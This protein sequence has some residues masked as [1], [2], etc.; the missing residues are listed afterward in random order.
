MSSLHI[1]IL[2]TLLTIIIADNRT[3]Y[4]TKS[5][6][7]LWCQE[8]ILS[9]SLFVYPNRIPIGI[10][11]TSNIKSVSYHLI[12]D[13]NNGLFQLKSRRLADFYFL[14][15]N[16]TRPFDINREYQDV[17]TLRIQANIITTHENLTEQTEVRVLFDHS[18]KTLFLIDSS[19]C[20]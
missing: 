10:Y 1:S 11:R 7:D 6:Y 4:F 17:Y 18:Y 19:S 2:C 14:I 12:D 13:N 20:C 9:N 3:F 8:N 16:I 15:I 5:N